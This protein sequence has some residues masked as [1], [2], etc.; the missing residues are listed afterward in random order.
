[1]TDVDEACTQAEAFR[2]E[3][4][5]RAKLVA[6]M[7][8]RFNEVFAR[9]NAPEGSNSPIAAALAAQEQ[10]LTLLEKPTTLKA[11]IDGIISA[12]HLRPGEKVVAGQPIVTITS[13]TAERI[14]GYVRAP[15]SVQPE[16]GMHVEI[17]PRTVKRLLGLGQVLAVGVQMEFISPARFVSGMSSNVFEQALP[18]VVSLPAELKLLPGQVVDL[19]F[20]DPPR[21]SPPATAAVQ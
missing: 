16:V 11:P 3:A 13:P 18:F 19:S 9:D 20:R 2:V 8:Q 17:R 12:V 15:V 6:Q 5:G 7:E 14:L 4:E 1:M 10:E 21:Q